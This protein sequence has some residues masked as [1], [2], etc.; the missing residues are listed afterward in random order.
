[1]ITL[2]TYVRHVLIHKIF[3]RNRILQVPRE[4]MFNMTA[5]SN[6]FRHADQS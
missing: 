2:V 3:L 5:T 4:R 1:V 6:F